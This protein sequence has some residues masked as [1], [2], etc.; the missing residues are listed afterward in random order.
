MIAQR[1]SCRRE[2]A[3]GLATSCNHTGAHLYVN[4]TPTYLAVTSGFP[5]LKQS[6]APSTSLAKRR[7]QRVPAPLCACQ[8]NSGGSI[9]P[10]QRYVGG[11]PAS[12]HCKQAWNVLPR[13]PKEEAEVQSR[14]GG[15]LELHQKR[16]PLCLPATRVGQ[17]KTWTLQK[18]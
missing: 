13:M 8:R 10:S 2:R 16:S 6:A 17:T 15:L 3:Y 11:D 14:A 5:H 4:R 12:E 1:S 9:Q 7:L 18:G